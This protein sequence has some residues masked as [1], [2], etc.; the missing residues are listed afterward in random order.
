MAA[1]RAEVIYSGDV[2]GVGFRYTAVAFASNYPA[3]SGYV[4]NLSDGRVELVAEGEEERI[5]AL[6]NDIKDDLREHIGEVSIEWSPAKGEFKDF[7]VRF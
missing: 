4:K 7:R 2:Q 3:I 1:K 5:E 6:L